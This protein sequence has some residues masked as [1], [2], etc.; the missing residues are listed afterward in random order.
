ME[1]DESLIDQGLCIV[2]R[3]WEAGLAHRDIKPAN[4]LVRD[5]RMLLIDSAFAEVRPSPWRQAVDLGNMMLVLAL[6]SDVR[7]VYDR[8]RLAVLRG[9][10]RRGV[11]GHPRADHALPA[12]PDDP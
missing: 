3:L 2:R 8:A 4:L 11:R 7:T 10:D 9:R 1:V 6:R 12:A 5:G